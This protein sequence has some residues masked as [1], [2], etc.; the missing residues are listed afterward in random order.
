MI[1]PKMYMFKKKIGNRFDVI[2]DVILLYRPT[3]NQIHVQY[4]AMKTLFRLII[5]QIF[6]M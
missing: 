5:C 1:S 2:N 4:V 6:E 3:A